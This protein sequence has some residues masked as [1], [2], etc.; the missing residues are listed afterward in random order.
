[1]ATSDNDADDTAVSK[2]NALIGNFKGITLTLFDAIRMVGGAFGI[3]A[4]VSTALLDATGTG[5]EEQAAPDASKSAVEAGDPAASYPSENDSDEEDDDDE[6]EMATQADD[7]GDGA[8]PEDNRL[9]SDQLT[10]LYQNKRKCVEKEERRVAQKNS[11]LGDSRA[12]MTWDMKQA[13]RNQIFSP[14]GAFARLSSELFAL[15]ERM[16]P[17]LSVDAVDYDMYEW[18]VKIKGGGFPPESG[19]AGDLE[20]LEAV[21]GYGYVQLRLHFKV[22][23]YPFYPPR[24]SLIRPKLEGFVPGAMVAHPKLHLRNWNPVKPIAAVIEHLRTFL[25]RFARVELRSEMNDEA[26]F[27]DGAYM[28]NLSQ[29]EMSLARLAACGTSCGSALLPPHF[30]ELYSKEEALDID[31]GGRDRGTDKG[32]NFIAVLSG[33]DLTSA[34]VEKTDAAARAE[35]SGASRAAAGTRVGPGGSGGGGSTAGNYWAKGTGYG[36]DTRDCGETGAG[37]GNGGSRQQWDAAAAQSAQAAEDTAV[38]TLLVDATKFIS[39]M[40]RGGTVAGG[41]SKKSF[42]PAVMSTSAAAV[43]MHGE[44]S[45][46][47]RVQDVVRRSCLAAFIARELRGCSFMD[48]VARSGYYTSLM[49]AALALSQSSCADLLIK[50]G[51]GGWSESGAGAM[52]GS[53][54]PWESESRS[55]TDDS[56]DIVATLEEIMKQA[57]IYIQ[58]VESAS[59]LQAQEAPEDAKGAAKVG[60][61]EGRK[62]GA[63][64]K[65]GG[66]AAGA[67]GSAPKGHG[68]TKTSKAGGGSGESPD[69]IWKMTAANELALA[70]LILKTGESVRAAATG[71]GAKK[72]AVGDAA[73]Q[74]RSQSQMR[75]ASAAVAAISVGPGMA[76]TSSDASDVSEEVYQE[77]LRPLVFDATTLDTQHAYASDARHDLRVGPHIARVAREVAGLGSTLPLSR[78]SSVLV[79]I[80]QERAVLWSIM[81]TGPEDTPYDGGCFIFDAFF[82]SGYPTAPPQLKFRT[83]GG[84]RVRFNPNLYKDGKVCLSLLGTWSGAK[85][86]MWDPVASTMLQVIVSIQSL[87]LVNQPYFNEPGYE[88]LIGTADGD[89]HSSQ[90]NAAVQESTL[91]YGM[92]E[93]LRK[94]P[95]AFAEAIKAHFKMRR[96]HLLGPVK[97]RWMEGATGER[98]ERLEKLYEELETELNKL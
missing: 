14:E 62:G 53:G 77:T 48:M 3:E 63:G 94:P 82:P 89:S 26:R 9:N 16:D 55:E 29:L 43:G 80:D 51:D 40:P 50:G 10:R 23:L 75:D 93:S 21:N 5:L 73:S 44:H 81:I 92:I 61:T 22:D 34:A 90:Y 65:L 28:D 24:V 42:T 47:D 18:D 64:S 37:G 41:K 74:R 11:E 39:S 2:L 95:T 13:A 76:T 88:R 56:G 66:S 83:T 97:E 4:E 20:V 69:A 38:Q 27:P 86:E 59:A 12:G 52:S 7:D 71:L 78:S 91:R 68:A 84:G 30:H 32:G 17:N 1:M 31:E 57:R 25:A 49:N 46:M 19:I 85:G 60:G 45:T 79:R 35:A 54:R 36:Y 6:E 58:S 67:A 8:L 70:Q 96:G 33:G 72:V 15:Q 98:K 87:I